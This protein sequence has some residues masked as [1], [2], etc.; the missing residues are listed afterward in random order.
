M[1]SRPDN[2]PADQDDYPMNV[3]R[4]A[5][6]GAATNGMLFGVTAG[7]T[8]TFLQAFSR[9]H[10]G[11]FRPIKLITRP[12]VL[13][14]TFAGIGYVAAFTN[15]TPLTLFVRSRAEQEQKRLRERQQ[16]HEHD[17]MVSRV[18]HHN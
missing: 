1:K 2:K 7:L 16:G 9:R 15:N 4:L 17:E 3:L 18:N 14:S 6:Y 12:L 13:G 10:N 8:F 11:S 5:A